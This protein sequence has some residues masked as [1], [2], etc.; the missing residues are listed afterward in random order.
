MA[1][2][3]QGLWLC[4]DRASGAWPTS[5]RT[6]SCFFVYYIDAGDG[7]HHT[8]DLLDDPGG[9]AGYEPSTRPFAPG[10]TAPTPM[11]GALVESLQLTLRLTTVFADNSGPQRHGPQASRRLQPS[12]CAGIRASPSTANFGHRPPAETQCQGKERPRRREVQELYR[13]RCVHGRELPELGLGEHHRAEWVRHET[14]QADL[15]GDLR[16]RV[17]TPRGPPRLLH[18]GRPTCR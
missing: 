5:S 15:P 1:E 17:R 13:L 14:T 11:A 18:G 6:S 4:G 2:D 7:R 9:R 8:G 12:F 16:L 10:L 3:L